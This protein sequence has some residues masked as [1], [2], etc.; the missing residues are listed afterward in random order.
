M[1]DSLNTTSATE[2]RQRLF[3]LCRFLSARACHRL[4]LLLLAAV[5]LFF[6]ALGQSLFAPYGIAMV[7]L[8]LPIF[9]MGASREQTEKENND[10]PLS[11][12]YRRYHYSPSDSTAYRISL[13][14]CMLLLLIWHKVQ[15]PVIAL[16]GI[17]LPLLYLALSLALYPILSR[18]LCLWFHRRLMNGRL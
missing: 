9:L 12:L 11:V 2:Q 3:A 5:G 13:L 18:I 10:S 7:C 8:I 15:S 6:T 17:S 16:F 14:L 1:N 4:M